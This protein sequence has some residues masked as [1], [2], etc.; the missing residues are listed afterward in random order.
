MAGLRPGSAS[1]MAFSRPLL[2]RAV[3]SFLLTLFLLLGTFLSTTVAADPSSRFLWL[4]DL[5]HDPHYNDAASYGASCSETSAAHYGEYGC[6][7]PL[8]LINSTLKFA[9]SVVPE[10]DFVLLTGDLARHGTDQL[11]APRKELSAMLAEAARLIRVHFPNSEIVI[12]LGN[13]DVTPD[14]Y[15][16]L[17]ENDSNSTLLDLVV[18][19]LREGDIFSSVDEEAT[20]RAGGF[21]ARDIGQHITLL[22]LNTII[23]SSFHEPDTSNVSDP[24]HQFQWLEQQ[25]QRAR[26]EGRR[27]LVVGHIPP[28]VGS[29]RHVQFW[30]SVYLQQYYD[31]IRKYQEGGIVAAQLFGHLHS[32]EFRV[33]TGVDAPLLLT[34]SVT[35]VYHTNPTFW[36]VQ[37][38]ER[39]GTILDYDAYYFDL[40]GGETPA[41]DLEWKMLYSFAEAY[42]IPDLTAPSL[43]GIVESLGSNQTVLNEFLSRLKANVTQPPCDDKCQV[44]WVCTLQSMDREYYNACLSSNGYAPEDEDKERLMLAMVAVALLGSV[45]V[46]LMGRR[47]WRNRQRRSQYVEAQPAAGEDGVVEIS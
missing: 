32:D 2:Q 8:R 47:W 4:S 17:D 13:N 30:H 5:H 12:S 46:G 38:D 27:V 37:Y 42:D 45:L 24:F 14:Y 23:Y 19:A 16:P 9:V 25:L 36:V 3:V 6:D 21:F 31:L 29:F 18:D 1:S 28:T 26:E 39:E 34:G 44:E 11:S 43:L 40:G 20:F 10:P 35:P 15:L 41:V 22:S 33:V 7:S